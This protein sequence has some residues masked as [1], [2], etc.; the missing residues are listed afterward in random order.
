MLS[1]GNFNSLKRFEPEIKLYTILTLIQQFYAELMT[2]SGQDLHTGPK[3]KP[4]K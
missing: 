3:L 4:S 2:L 1:L